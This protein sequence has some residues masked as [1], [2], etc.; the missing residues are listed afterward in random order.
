VAAG[1]EALQQTRLHRQEPQPRGA[2]SRL[3]RM[4][5]HA[6]AAGE[7]EETIGGKYFRSIMRKKNTKRRRTRR[8]RI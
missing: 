4:H 3:R 7:E 1:R 2:E 5:R 6:G 8:R